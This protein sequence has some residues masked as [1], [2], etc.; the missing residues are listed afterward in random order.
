[1]RMHSDTGAADLGD[2]ED[3]GIHCGVRDHA[4]DGDGTLLPKPVAAVL[5]LR[6]ASAMHI[7]P[8]TRGLQS[9]RQ[10]HTQRCS[11][12]LSVCLRV[13]VAVVDENCVCADKVEPLASSAC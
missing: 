6:R 9:W 12:H 7:R 10:C 2:A 3:V 4:I 8:G 1:M 11:R 5:G 13:E